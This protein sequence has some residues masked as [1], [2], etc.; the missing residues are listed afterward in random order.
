MKSS[1]VV[2]A[3]SLFLVVGQR[4]RLAGELGFEPRFSESESDVLPLNYSPAG[5]QEAIVLHRA[6]GGRLSPG[7]I[8]LILQ[9]HRARAHQAMRR[10]LV[11]TVTIPSRVKATTSRNTIRG[12]P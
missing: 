4:L 12:L 8:S 11:A 2:D 3:F 5:G 10:G 6:P 9:V 1:S 7:A